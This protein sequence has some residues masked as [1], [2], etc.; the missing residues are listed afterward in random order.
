MIK[1]CFIVIGLLLPLRLFAHKVEYTLLEKGFGLEARYADGTAISYSGVK[2]FAPEDVANPFQE[3]STDKHGRFVFYPD[4]PGKWKIEVND[5]MGHGVI[6]DIDI[7]DGLTVLRGV[8]H[9]RPLLE[10]IIMGICIIFG[11]TGMLFYLA[12]RKRLK[13]YS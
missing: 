10:T 12:A 13:S 8:E 5:G 11:I 3:G 4:K 6:A 7:T 1:L 2:V 9:G